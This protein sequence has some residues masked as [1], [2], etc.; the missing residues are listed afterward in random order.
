M[1]AAWI[2][3]ADPIAILREPVSRIDLLLRHA[4][5]IQRETKGG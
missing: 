5:R 3:R 2:W 4:E 1:N